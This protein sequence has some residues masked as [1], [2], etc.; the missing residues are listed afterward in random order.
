MKDLTLH[1]ISSFLPSSLEVFETYGV[2]YY[3]KGWRTIAQVCDELKIDAVILMKA[4]SENELS[5]T[6]AKGYE[7]YY[8]LGI[9]DLIA[10]IRNKFHARER[11]DIT[12]MSLVLKELAEKFADNKGFQKLKDDFAGLSDDFLVHAE[13]E[14]EN[15]FPMI[16]QMANAEKNM[17]VLAINRVFHN[18]IWLYEKEHDDSTTLIDEIAA[19]A[20]SLRSVAVEDQLLED[21]LIDLERFIKELHV[22]LHVENNI[23]FP[24]ARLL[25][26]RLK[27][28]ID[29]N[30]DLRHISE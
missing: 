4:L 26:S 21:L 22:H 13:H 29:K 6:D 10:R 18:E 8:D 2:D 19:Q 5:D 11:A 15:L 24:K 9:D 7:S 20:K 25:E 14:E 17:N 28:K 1:E 23:L 16:L 30:T 12:K 3:R 27:L